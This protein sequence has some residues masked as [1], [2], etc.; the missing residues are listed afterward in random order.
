MPGDLEGTKGDWIEE[1]PDY[2]G[3]CRSLD[4]NVG[5]LVDY[6]K[7]AGLYENTIIFYTSDH[8]SH[9]RTRNQDISVP[10]MT[11]AFIYRFSQRAAASTGAMWS[12]NW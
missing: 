5:R 11:A 8:G 9:F 12:M 3:C 10:A 1:M 6:L 2:L 4:E 7:K